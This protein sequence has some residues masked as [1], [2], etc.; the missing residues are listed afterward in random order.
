[1]PWFLMPPT[2]KKLEM[3]VGLRCKRRSG[4]DLASQLYIAMTQRFGVGSF[5]DSIIVRQDR[6]VDL[7]KNL[8]ADVAVDRT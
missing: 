5:L 3:K 4:G 2:W 6:S 7:L 8:C 1:M